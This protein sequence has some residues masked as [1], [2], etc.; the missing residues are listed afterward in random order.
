MILKQPWWYW[1][2]LSLSVCFPSSPPTFLYNHLCPE[3]L[4]KKGRDFLWSTRSPS[5]PPVGPGTGHPV[6][7]SNASQPPCLAPPPPSPM[8]L[9][10]LGPVAPVTKV[11]RN[12]Y[13]GCR[14]CYTRDHHYPDTLW[15][16]KLCHCHII[17]MFR[18]CNL[19]NHSSSDHY[20]YLCPA[21][22]LFRLEYKP[23]HN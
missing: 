6:G 11:N 10:H 13:S 20:L 8:W 4:P 12:M 9:M 17:T 16:T 5:P 22:T 14:V 2:D 1:I 23:L 21:E 18:C 19:K 7:H 15:I 3:I